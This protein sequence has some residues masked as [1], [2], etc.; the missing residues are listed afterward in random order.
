MYLLSSVSL[1]SLFLSAFHLVSL[2]SSSD[3]LT[4]PFPLRAM[5]SPKSNV[6]LPP[7]SHFLRLSQPLYLFLHEITSYICL[8]S[9]LKKKKKNQLQ[10][11]SYRTSLLLMM[12][13]PS[14]NS[15]PH[16]CYDI[17]PTLDFSPLSSIENNLISFIYRILAT[18]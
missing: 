9:C 12:L 14:W 3:H 5:L 6:Y 10:S 7:L 1:A 16:D 4:Y 8:S 18:V 2:H 17:T 15:F 13:G 11:L